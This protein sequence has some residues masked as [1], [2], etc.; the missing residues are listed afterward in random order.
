[1][2]Q[3]LY[4]WA[5]TPPETLTPEIEALRHEFAANFKSVEALKPP[6]HITLYKPFKVPEPVTSAEAERFRRWISTQPAFTL[7][8]DNF[9]FFENARSPVVYIVVTPNADL[10]MLNSGLSQLTRKTFNFDNENSNPYHPHITIG[11]RDILPVFP[12]VKQ[13]YSKRIYHASFQV[14]DICLFKHNGKKWEVQ[15]RF[16]LGAHHAH[17]N[18]L[19]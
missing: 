15:H 18:E 6:V 8:L 7:E 10:K 12:E 19:W 17:Q 3:C 11:Y 5:V 14:P 4:L 16:P 2:S 13:A 9:G 1:M